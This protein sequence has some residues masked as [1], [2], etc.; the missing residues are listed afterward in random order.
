MQELVIDNFAGN[1][2]AS[3]RHKRAVDAN[4]VQFYQTQ[5]AA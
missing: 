5:L 3:S 2:G 1:G 4:Y